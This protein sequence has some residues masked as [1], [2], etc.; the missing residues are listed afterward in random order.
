MGITVTS[1][2]VEYHRFGRPGFHPLSPDSRFI[3]TTGWDGLATEVTPSLDHEGVLRAIHHLRYAGGRGPRVDV[4]RQTLAAEAR[5]FL[6]NLKPGPGELLQID[7]VTNAAELWAIPFEACFEGTTWIDDPGSGVVLTRRIRGEFTSQRHLWPTRPRILFAHAPIA[8]DLEPSLVVDHVAALRAALDPWL[9]SRDEA[10][11]LA[12]REI[13]SVTAL[14]DAVGATSPTSVHILAHG[15]P[16]PA[17]PGLPQRQQ[18]GLRFGPP[19]APGTPADDIGNALTSGTLPYLVTLM[20]CDSGNQSDPIFAV[21]SVV[22]DLH[23]RGIPVVVGSQLPLTKAGSSVFTRGFYEPVCRGEDV[24]VALH[25]ARVAVKQA[26]STGH[27]WLSIVGY[28]RLPPEGYADHLIEVALLAELGMLRGLQTRMD[29][30]LESP[31]A[32]AA[33]FDDVEALIR[34]RR[35]SLR[36]RRRQLGNRRDLLDESRGLEA[37]A[38]KRLAEFLFRRGQRFPADRNARLKAS[39]DALSEARQL[40]AEAYAGDLHGHWLGLQQLSLETVLDGRVSRDLD[41]AMVRRAAELVRD[42]AVADGRSADCWSCAT[43]LE[44]SLLDP[45][46]GEAAVDDAAAVV[47]LFLDRVRAAAPGDRDAALF[48][49]DSACRQLRRYVEWW[50]TGNG[51]F[52]GREDLSKRAG[53]VLPTL[54]EA[55]RAARGGRTTTSVAE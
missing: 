22:Q 17:D 55:L 54:E 19:G 34:D 10:N 27:D 49:L 8:A 37:S 31:D 4:A 51:F 42:A 40:Y 26:P 28:V 50:T 29:E 23:R 41:M 20:A 52:P 39:R 3:R 38:C 24:R 16:A 2:M 7:V 12:I 13:G 33:Q 47:G 43:L 5:R 30:I 36:E 32:T 45:T 9:S 35:R 48:A 15:A 25:Q 6:P 11:Y 44:L 14:E 53:A 1:Q 18:W 46:G 21:A